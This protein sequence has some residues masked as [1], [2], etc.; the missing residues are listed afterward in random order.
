MTHADGTSEVL[1][2]DTEWTAL[3]YKVRDASVR[4]FASYYPMDASMLD[5]LDVK[6]KALR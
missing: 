6:L 1:K 4:D 2:S 5:E 3:W